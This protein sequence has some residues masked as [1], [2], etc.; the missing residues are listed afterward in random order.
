MQLQCHIGA[1]CSYNATLKHC[2][3]TMPHWSTVHSYN[4][5]LKHCAQLQCHIGALCTVTMPHWSTV[6]LQCRIGALCSYNATSHVFLRTQM[7]KRGTHP[8]PHGS[9][10][11][12]RGTQR[13]T[14]LMDHEYI[15]GGHTGKHTPPTDHVQCLHIT[16][17]HTPSFL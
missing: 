2:A 12:P 10:K 5:T 11:Y 13:E 7:I 14:P 3:V 6:Q 16:G 1:L 15:T 9:C 8:L 17:G 4:A